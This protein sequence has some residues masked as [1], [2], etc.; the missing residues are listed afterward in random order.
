MTHGINMH[1]DILEEH[2]PEKIKF[3]FQDIL[4]S[5]EL[6]SIEL[7]KK[8][9]YEIFYNHIFKD[10]CYNKCHNTGTESF[11]DVS[12]IT[13]EQLEKEL[14]NHL[15]E[16]ND[17]THQNY[18][19]YARI[20]SYMRSKWFVADKSEFHSNRD[21]LV[22]STL[23]CIKLLDAYTFHLR[24]NDKVRDALLSLCYE[25]QYVMRYSSKSNDEVEL[26]KSLALADAHI[27]STII[28]L[29][30]ILGSWDVVFKKKY[31]LIEML[32]SFVRIKPWWYMG[33]AKRIAGIYHENLKKI[34]FKKK[35]KRAWNAFL[36][37]FKPCKQTYSLY[38]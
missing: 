34:I 11:K 2:I 22:V 9:K 35:I 18:Y 8:F 23:T 33:D 31:T 17:L 28:T 30:N 36:D 10:T 16:F 32:E 7:W 5:K 20:G 24:W 1:L 3:P 12:N 14:G 37:I 19:I 6:D 13:L 27:A 15:K 38:K 4:K 21:Y 26:N 25:L 29:Y